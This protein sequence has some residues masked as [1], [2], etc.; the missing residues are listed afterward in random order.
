MTDSV[1]NLG[2]ILARGASRRMGFPKGQ[3]LV[4]GNGQSF[5]ASVVHL[6]RGLDWPCLIVTRH[7]LVDRY[8]PLLEP[9]ARV[10]WLA[11]DGQGDTA[12]S[13]QLAWRHCRDLGWSGSTLWAHPVD[14]P[15]VLPAT[16]ARMSREAEALPGN[17]L[18]PLHRG[19]PGHPVAL[20]WAVL[21]ELLAGADDQTLGR[22]MR[23]LLQGLAPERQVS[24]EV[25]DPGVVQDFDEPSAIQ[26]S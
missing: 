24:L 7:D 23:H 13:L 21:G 9:D 3:A 18:R 25:P 16:V 11:A 14:L 15:L 4:A 19:Q 12:R 6:Y 2:V 17:V 26:E 22:P 20:P 8:R 1:G 10:S 5:L